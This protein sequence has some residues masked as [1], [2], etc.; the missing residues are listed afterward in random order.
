[1]NLIKAVSLCYRT[2]SGCLSLPYA[3]LPSCWRD[4]GK[5]DQKVFTWSIES[6]LCMELSIATCM[7][8]STVHASSQLWACHIWKFCVTIF[9]TV[10]KIRIA[11]TPIGVKIECSDSALIM[12][13]LPLRLA[14]HP[15]TFTPSHTHTHTHT[16]FP[17]CRDKWL[18]AVYSVVFVIVATVNLVM[19]VYL[20]VAVVIEVCIRVHVRVPVP[21]HCSL[22]V[23]GVD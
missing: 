20:L 7:V 19:F 8:A 3:K 11:C 4:N 9:R 22:M 5:N 13:S 17:T 15:N 16:P 18:I 21:S 23:H 14:S 12:T 10:T 6:V 1:M 2:Y